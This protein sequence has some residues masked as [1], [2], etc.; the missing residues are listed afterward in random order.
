MLAFPFAGTSRLYLLFGRQ[1]GG[2]STNFGKHIRKVGLKRCLL[3]E[4]SLH[5]VLVHYLGKRGRR[6]AHVVKLERRG[7]HAS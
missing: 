5:A 2:A 6:N 4:S 1:H 3:A 7:P